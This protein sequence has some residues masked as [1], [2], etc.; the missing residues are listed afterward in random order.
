MRSGRFRRI[1]L[2]TLLGF[3]ASLAVFAGPPFLT[4]DPETVEPGHY[5]LYLFSTYDRIP[6]STSLRAPAL[7][8]NVGAAPNLQLHVAVPFAWSETAGG[9]RHSGWG[10]VEVG[11]KY[12]FVQETETTPQIGVFPMA[13]LPLGNAGRDLG[14]GQAWF[15]LPLWIQKSWGPWT[16]YGGGGWAINHAPGMRDHAFGGWLLQRAVGE[17]LTLGGEVFAQGA[18]AE[19]GQGTILA[20]A[21]GIVTLSPGLSLLFSAGR[22]LGGERHTIAY[23]GLQWA[24]GRDSAARTSG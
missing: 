13:L 17:H 3:G 22:S 12:R 20:N 16:T 6:G 7:E 2:C 18:D 24:W 1:A 23:L 9:P 19:G 14:N 8:F 5:E 4:D 15:V 11:L 10:D 21:G